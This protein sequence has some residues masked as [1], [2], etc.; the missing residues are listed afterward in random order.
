MAVVSDKQAAV[1][2]TNFFRIEGETEKNAGLVSQSLSHRDGAGGRER[3]L[4]RDAL[5]LFCGF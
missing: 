1:H 5:F 2:S 3:G 4:V